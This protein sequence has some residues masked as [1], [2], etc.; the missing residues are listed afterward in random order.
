MYEYPIFKHLIQFSNLVDPVS[1]KLQKGP[2]MPPMP[3]NNQHYEE[4]SEGS[5]DEE[6][7][8]EKE[9]GE[10]QSQGHFE[11]GESDGGQPGSQQNNGQAANGNYDQM[12][13]YNPAMISGITT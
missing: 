7:E 5:H 11:G 4:D 2:E 6:D 13:M 12:A 9:G 10:K 3:I 8:D 1:G